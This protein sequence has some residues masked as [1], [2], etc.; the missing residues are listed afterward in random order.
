M[1]PDDGIDVSNSKLPM[2][3]QVVKE[4]LAWGSGLEAP[5]RKANKA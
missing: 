4:N 2:R 1:F 5:L 3:D